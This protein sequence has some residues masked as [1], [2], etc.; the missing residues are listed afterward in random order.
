MTITERRAVVRKVYEFVSFIND[1]L[2]SHEFT[3]E[4][5]TLAFDIVYQEWRR[6]H[7][8]PFGRYLEERGIDYV[9]DRLMIA[10]Y[11]LT[12]SYRDEFLRQTG[13][14]S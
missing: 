1:N 8:Y 2:E 11:A 9:V 4:D 12:L 13:S 3:D 5:M 7:R 14:G 10:S 6:T